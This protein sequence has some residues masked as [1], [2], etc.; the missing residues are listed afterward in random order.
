MVK[1]KF[2]PKTAIQRIR[3]AKRFSKPQE[4]VSAQK[5]EDI[6]TKAILAKKFMSDDN[7]LF[8]LMQD[9]LKQAEDMILENRVREVREE[10][11]ITDFLKKTFVTPK[12][13]QDD[14][15]V[16]RIK[17]IREF[18]G[19]LEGWIQEREDREKEESVGVIAI[20]RD[21]DKR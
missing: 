12:K 15:I 2:V 11:M 14:E 16:G 21:N 19:T 3:D 7:I 17:F 10:H 6:E 8:L 18:L 5:W 13:I 20:Q 1:K 4:T 9:S